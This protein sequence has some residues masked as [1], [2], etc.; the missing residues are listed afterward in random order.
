MG[1]RRGAAA[2][3]LGGSDRAEAGDAGAGDEILGPERGDDVPAV[4]ARAK[5]MPGSAMAR[6]TVRLPTADRAETT[7]PMI[8]PAGRTKPAPRAGA[9]AAIDGEGGADGDAD[10]QAEQR[11]EHGEQQ[12]AEAG[13]HQ[14]GDDIAPGRVGAEPVGGVGFGEGREDGGAVR[15]PDQRDEGGNHARRR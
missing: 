8:S 2:S 5:R 14:G 3:A 13:R 1:S 6:M 4:A 12:R 7:R 11:A 15:S 10:E 9:R